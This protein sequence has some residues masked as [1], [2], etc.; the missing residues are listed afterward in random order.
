MRNIIPYDET[1]SPSVAANTEQV[2]YTFAVPIKA[3]LRIRKFAN[4]LPDAT[5]WT[6]ITWSLRR[7]NIGIPPY[8]AVKDQI[9][10]SAQTEEVALPFILNGGDV[11]TVVAINASLVT[12]FVVGF[13]LMFD[14][15]EE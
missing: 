8:N 1:A 4:Y 6:Q 10:Y 3:K 2:L 9:G 13:R 15:Y 5:G 7:N 11:L 12:A 14:L